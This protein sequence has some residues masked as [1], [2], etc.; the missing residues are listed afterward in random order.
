MLKWATFRTCELPGTTPVVGTRN[1]P[2]LF[3]NIM[4]GISSMKVAQLRAELEKRGV[5][6][7]KGLKKAQLVAQLQQ[8][9]DDEKLEAEVNYRIFHGMWMLETKF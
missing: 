2:F 7:L 6:N 9:L 5:A 3:S 1:L 4:A 8:L